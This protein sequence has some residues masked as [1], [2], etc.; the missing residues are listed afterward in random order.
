M[1]IGRPPKLFSNEQVHALGEDLI[2]WITN[3]GKGN[4]Q[5]VRWYFIKHNMLKGDWKELKQRESFRP[6]HELA[7]SLMAENV[8]LNEDIPQSY[9]NRYLC[10]Y[11]KDLHEFEEENRDR[12]SQRR[13]VEKQDDGSEAV[14]KLEVLGEFFSKVHSMPKPTEDKEPSPDRS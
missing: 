8:A 9:G 12:E 5:F 13:R 3:E 4:I 11:D 6:Y 14:K 7:I 1:Q 2:N 10:Y